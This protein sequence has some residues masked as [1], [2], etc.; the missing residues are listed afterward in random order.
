M[1]KKSYFFTP[2]IK[3]ILKE[4]KTYPY[5]LYR[6]V[7]EKI[8]GLILKKDELLNPSI[9]T[10]YVK[11]NTPIYI[12]S[13][14]RRHYQQYIQKNISDM[15]NN[16]N[17]SLDSKASLINHIATETMND[18]FE[19]DVTSENL[20]KIDTV[21]NHSIKLM[22]SEYKAMQSML[23][24][25]SY[26][27]YTYTHCIDVATYAI[28]FGIFLNFEENDLGVLG[29]AAMLHDLGKKEIDSNI[30]TKNGK[31]T[32]EEFEIVKAHPVYSVKLLK[33]MG[34]TEKKL[35][36]AIAQHHEKCNG[37]GYPL[38]LKDNEISEFAKIISICD[39]FNA[40]TT[41]RTY[42]DRMSSFNAFEIMCN[43]MIDD[44]SKVHLL[45]FIKF[46]GYN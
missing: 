36:T 37:K 5:S 17:I 45:K 38:G 34:E 29:K 22:L 6:Q 2:I 30:I 11:K 16:E 8:F 15:I 28:A 42:K 39:V 33:E 24:V 31:L 43:E 20:S 13:S 27:Y 3:D 46:M 1:T 14:E 35:L 23:K 9:D 12:K 26:D 41:R 4:G 44:L 25:T 10:Q 21:I 18:L 32:K 7:D 40:L 19:S